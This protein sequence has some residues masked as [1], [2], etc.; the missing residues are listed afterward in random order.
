MVVDST[1]ARS[2]MDGDDA[3][4]KSAE[5]PGT[6]ELAAAQ[7]LDI[8]DSQADTQLTQGDD[9]LITVEEY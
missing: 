1:P 5:E 3:M 7:E 8:S 4:D 2:A 6:Q 9:S